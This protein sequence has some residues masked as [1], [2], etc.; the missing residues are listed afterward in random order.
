MF[1]SLPHGLALLLCPQ[2]SLQTNLIAGGDG[3]VVDEQYKQ[4]AA[5]G[6]QYWANLEARVISAKGKSVTEETLNVRLQNIQGTT[7]KL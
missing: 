7:T 2:E 6:W 5:G 3:E 1:G 4:S